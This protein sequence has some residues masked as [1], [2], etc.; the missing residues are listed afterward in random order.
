MNAS[1]WGKLEWAGRNKRDYVIIN[2]RG[3][4]HFQG[5]RHRRYGDGDSMA[6]WTSGVHL[7][8]QQYP[9]PYPIRCRMGFDLSSGE[10]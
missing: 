2:V 6:L 10:D 4:F 8:I 5:M 1:T 7:Y 3:N 9:Y